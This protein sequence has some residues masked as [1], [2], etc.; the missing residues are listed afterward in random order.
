[1]VLGVRSR[2]FLLSFVLV[3]IASLS[4][5]VYL[6]RK[7][8]PMLERTVEVELL[9]HARMVRET[10]IARTGDHTVEELNRLADR[11]G[12]AV[13]SRV[14]LIRNDGTVLGDSNL[15]EAEVRAAE[16]HA[17][18][19]EVIAA[20]ASG[21]GSAR[22]YSATLRTE[23]L[24]VAVRYELRSG[25][26]V[27]RVA[28]PLI[29]VEALVRRLRLFVAVAGL[30]GLVV[31]TFVSVMAA[32]LFARPFRSLVD[33]A[34]ALARGERTRIEVAPAG[35][36]GHLAGS[37]NR[38]SED[39]EQAVR[40]LADERDRFHTVLEAM[41][42][43]VITLDSANRVTLA[44]PMAMEFLGLRVPP[45]ERPLKEI[46]RSS[47]LER[48]L[49]GDEPV[50]PISLEFDL[51]VARRVLTRITP[52]RATGGHIIVMHDVS[53]MR[54]LET[55]RRDF[56]ANVSHEL[57]T[58]I[59]VILANSETLADGGV[60]DTDQAARFLASIHSNAE[61]LS[62][63][64][65]DLLDLSKI[66][67]GR[68]PLAL[69][70]TEIEPEL[71]KAIEAMLG[72]ARMKRQT[73]ESSGGESRTVVADPTA[74]EQVLLN[75]LDNAVKYTPE[76]GRIEVR[77]GTLDDAVR[78]EVVDDGPGIEPRHCSRLFERFYRVDPG[79]SRELG[80]TGL[81]LAIVKH[82]V[83]S[84]GGHV[85]VEAASPHG[86]RFWFTLQSAIRSD[87]E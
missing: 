56:V 6:E 36:I 67:A 14:T 66:E 83:E 5:S 71:R 3:A 9:R 84:M 28:L 74:L 65:A 73:I 48:L 61:R 31:A 63:L 75:L 43:A 4:S 72:P 77:L 53:E 81:G 64:I 78:V 15:S 30:I 39:L 32:N 8:R 62:R 45:V 42:D 35:E 87:S 49:D 20:L 82:L 59:S 60:P 7:L 79:R 10:L 18:R 50:G 2:L 37:I 55:I 33:K 26:G 34:R 47:E 41:A 52:M 1:M 29:E 38:I 80:G 13:A 85:G 27:A 58:P 23:M 69:R 22:R 12:N 70:P 57:R 24:Y 54:R 17:S 86:S 76:G 40:A 25:A 11:L 44:N 68:Y 51:P 16:N 21:A 19:P 46:I